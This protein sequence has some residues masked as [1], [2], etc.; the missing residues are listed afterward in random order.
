MRRIKTIAAVV[1]LIAAY[2]AAG[3]ADYRDAVEA[4]EMEREWPRPV[5]G[6]EEDF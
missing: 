6:Y 2:C 1:F 5:E 3:T 4:E